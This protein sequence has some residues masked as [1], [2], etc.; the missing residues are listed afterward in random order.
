[1]EE[2][3]PEKVTTL[4]KNYADLVAAGPCDCPGDQFSRTYPPFDISRPATA[5]GRPI[6][7]HLIP[8]SRG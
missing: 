3:M 2:D 4:T 6:R 1:M 5:L 8:A 7:I